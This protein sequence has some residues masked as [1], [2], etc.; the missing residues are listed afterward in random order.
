MVPIEGVESLPELSFMVFLSHNGE[1]R[2]F[3]HFSV[4][5]PCFVVRGPWGD[6]D[7][8][9]F[10]PLTSHL[11]PLTTNSCLLIISGAEGRLNI[12][13]ISPQH[14]NGDEYKKVILKI[15]ISMFYVSTI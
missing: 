13:A 4:C 10:G 15:P 7:W 8:R 12:S 6:S 1:K 9:C 5:S 2:L 11:S 14:N 3:G